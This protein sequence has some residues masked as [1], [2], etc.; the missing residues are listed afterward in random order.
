MTSILAL[1]EGKVIQI[2][3]AKAV[4]SSGTTVYT[5]SFVIE[6]DEYFTVFIK[7]SGTNP[8]LKIVRCYNFSITEETAG[9]PESD[10][11]AEIEIDGTEDEMIADFTK[12]VWTINAEHPKYS[13][14]MRYKVTGLASNGADTTLSMVVVK[15]KK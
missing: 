5:N 13:I 12:K 15:Q 1:S 2:A 6:A 3:D 11:W 7:A 10:K 4:V 9:E 14:W 8:H